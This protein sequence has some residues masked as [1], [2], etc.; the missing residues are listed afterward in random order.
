MMVFAP[1]LWRDIGD[2]ALDDLEQ[3]L[4]HALARDVASDR[5]VVGLAGDLVDFVYVD[6]A[7]LGAWDIKI[8]HL[9]EPKQDVLDILADVAGLGEG[10]GVGDAEGY[11][12]D[13]GERLGEVR[14]AT[15][16]GADEKDIALA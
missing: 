11:V 9:D 14:L 8:G 12:E 10:G 15:A 4:L 2:R 1:T 6:D 13:F 7:A 16:G 5:G 3:R